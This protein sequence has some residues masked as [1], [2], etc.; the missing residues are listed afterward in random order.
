M[1]GDSGDLAMPSGSAPLDA[2]RGRR[3]LGRILI[4]L[5]REPA[6]Q[7]PARVYLRELLA[8]IQ[9]QGQALKRQSFGFGVERPGPVFARTG[10]GVVALLDKRPSERGL[11]LLELTNRR[12]IRRKIEQPPLLHLVEDEHQPMPGELEREQIWLRTIREQARL[13]HQAAQRHRLGI[14]LG[15]QIHGHLNG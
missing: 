12:M 14:A 2:R 6:L 11:C 8:R 3:T 1:P 7:L 15:G 13:E 5:A 4:Q 9:R 10:L